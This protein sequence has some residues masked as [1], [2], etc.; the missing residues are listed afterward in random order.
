MVGYSPS[1]SM[2]NLIS[3]SPHQPLL[4]IAPA[5]GG[6]HV[7][8][9]PL[10][11]VDDHVGFQVAQGVAAPE[12]GMEIGGLL[13]HLSQAVVHLVETGAGARRMAVLQRDP[14]ASAKG[15]LPEAVERPV[16]V[17][18]HR[19]R[20]D[21]GDGPGGGAI[22]VLEAEGHGEEVGERALHR[23]LFLP[24]PVDAQD[25]I[26]VHDA[27]AE[28][29]AL[30][31]AGALDLC[32]DGRRARLDGHIGAAFPAAPQLARRPVWLRVGHRART[33]GAGRILCTDGTRRAPR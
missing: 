23:R 13:R 10:D 16:G 8:A 33:L 18:R 9:A 12:L 11:A 32:Q 14:G 31:G 22:R 15:H 28:P 1:P 3:P 2:K 20:A 17:H 29:H 6:A 5:H 4:L 27:A 26:P 25:E 7:V 24:F 30:D 21:L 19:E